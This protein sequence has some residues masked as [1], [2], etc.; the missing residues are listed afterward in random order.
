[1]SKFIE[2]GTINVDHAI[3]GS[4]DLDQCGIVHAKLQT[5]LFVPFLTGVSKGIIRRKL[6]KQMLIQFLEMDEKSA[7]KFMEC[8]SKFKPESIRNEYYSDLLT[9]LD[10]DI[11]LE[12]TKTQNYSKYFHCLF[13]VPYDRLADIVVCSMIFLGI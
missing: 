10:E 3:F 6:I 9:W 13:I 5:M 2:P 1:M 12:G 8:F 11:N 7:E 4:P